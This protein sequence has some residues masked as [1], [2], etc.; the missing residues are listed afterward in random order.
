LWHVRGDKR[1]WVYPAGH[2]TLF[3]QEVMEDIFASFA[4]EEAAYAEDFDK[5]AAQFD[6]SPGDVMCWPQN[7]PHRVTNVRGLNVSLS[8]VFQTEDSERRKLIY[9]ANRLFRRKYGIP[10]RSTQETG[11][12]ASMKRTAFRAFRKLGF[13]HT[14][15][16]RAYVAKLRIDPDAP[17]GCVPVDGD[18]VLTEFSRKEFTLQKDQSGM[19]LLQQQK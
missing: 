17:A 3:A 4:D 18:P 1:L 15:P 6:V 19:V 14:P 7:A 8:T 13:V 9:C 16:R 5:L 12:A 11:I 10:L 2:R